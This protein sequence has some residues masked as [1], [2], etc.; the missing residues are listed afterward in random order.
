MADMMDVWDH[1]DEWRQR[2]K[3][4]LVTVTRHK[5]VPSA[6]ATDGP[7]RWAVYAYVYPDHPHFS[8]F[9][10]TRSLSQEAATVLPLHAG[11]SMVCYHYD[12][13]CKITSVQVGA[14]YNH[15]YDDGYTHCGDA[16]EAYAVFRDAGELY[17]WL[18][19]P[20]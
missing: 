5:V 9:D 3:D 7:H 17:G 18:E 10:G 15:L 19:A 20:N 4:F 1:K 2:G 14:D 8:K 16:G 11:A 13:H 6:I 12:Q